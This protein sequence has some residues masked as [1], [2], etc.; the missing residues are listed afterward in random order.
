MTKN[1]NNICAENMNREFYYARDATG[2][3]FYPKQISSEQDMLNVDT[4]SENAP[5][6]AP[7]DEN[8]P[9]GENVPE[10]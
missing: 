3:E 10:N 7:E 1:D 9:A 6:D 2:N 5:E 4:A 8:V